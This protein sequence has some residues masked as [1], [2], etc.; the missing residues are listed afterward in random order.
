M[1]PHFE[2]YRDDGKLTHTAYYH[3][4]DTASSAIAKNAAS[5]H[6]AAEEM[7]RQTG[8]KAVEVADGLGSVCVHL[9]NRY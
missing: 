5:K 8:G 4:T 6:L 1:S 3:Q 2:F 7:I 9:P